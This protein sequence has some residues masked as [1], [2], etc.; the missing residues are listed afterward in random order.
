M[1]DTKHTPEILKEKTTP[2]GI[3]RLLASDFVEGIGPA[4]ARRLVDAFGAET[5]R[6]LAD[7]PE[8]CSEI[9]GLGE[10]RNAAP[11]IRNSN[12]RHPLSE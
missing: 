11:T 6:V 2:E 7:D 1:K 10:A 9:K 8:R 3:E 12:F 5:L 4:Y